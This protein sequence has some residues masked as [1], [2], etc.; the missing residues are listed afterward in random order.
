MWLISLYFI[1]QILLIK[2]FKIRL[3]III[4]YL[5]L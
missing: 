3:N 4:W 1:D 5:N 2:K